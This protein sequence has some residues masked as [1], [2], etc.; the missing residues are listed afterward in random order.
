VPGLQSQIYPRTSLI[1]NGSTTVYK[2]GLV[3]LNSFVTPNVLNNDYSI[4]GDVTV[5]ADGGNGVV[6]AEGGR[7]GG[8]AL[9][10]N[11]RCSYVLLQLC[12]AWGMYRWKGTEKL[13][14]GSH[15][16]KFGFVYDGGG[17]GKGGVGTLSVDGKTVDTH[18]VEKTIMLCHG[19]A[20]CGTLGCGINTDFAS[21]GQTNIVML[22]TDDPGWND[23]GAYNDGG[24]V[25]L[26]CAIV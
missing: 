3:A 5:K 8:Y 12:H 24:T 25:H 6:V 23:F 26:D 9:W 2:P 17:V 18:G 4:E 7:F 20:G 22:M 1:G 14:A 16:L 21:A 10:L 13:T 11:Q 19:P 15:K